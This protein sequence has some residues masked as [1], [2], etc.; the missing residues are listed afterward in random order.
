VLVTL[1]PCISF[2]RSLKADWSDVTRR[3]PTQLYATLN[4]HAHVLRGS[5]ASWR[6]LNASNTNNIV[7]NVNKNTNYF[8]TIIRYSKSQDN[9]VGIATGYRLDSWGSSPGRGKISFSTPQRPDQLWGQLVSSSL[10]TEGS[11]GVKADHSL[12][13]SAEIKNCGVIPPLSHMSPW[14][15]A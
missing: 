12:P 14:H 1:I 7:V 4:C 13:S 9:S 2:V 5:D 11:V 15:S 3:R 8:R 10:G 6:N